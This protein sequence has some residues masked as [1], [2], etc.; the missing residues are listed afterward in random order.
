MP[1]RSTDADVHTHTFPD[2][3]GDA[4]TQPDHNAVEH[5]NQYSDTTALDDHLR[6]SG[7]QR[8]QYR[9]VLGERWR[10]EHARTDQQGRGKQSLAKIELHKSLPLM[11]RTV[12]RP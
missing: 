11:G 5:T 2:I 6:Q 9:R 1:R 4:D 12:A 7:R 8:S 3:D 10:C